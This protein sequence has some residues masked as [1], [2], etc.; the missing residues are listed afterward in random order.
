MKQRGTMKPIHFRVLKSIGL[1]FQKIKN[2][3]VLFSMIGLLLALTMITPD[4]SV[5]L[6]NPWQ[7]IVNHSTKECANLRIGFGD[8]DPKDCSIPEGWE[9]PE[10]EKFSNNPICPKGYDRI[11]RFEGEQC[12]KL[13]QAG[14]NSQHSP[15]R[16]GFGCA[17]RL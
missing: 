10:Y 3:G 17:P 11:G 8:D 1:S 12:L 16:R 2:Q 14:Y 9:E 7:L 4:T 5:S 13:S 6:P 15:P